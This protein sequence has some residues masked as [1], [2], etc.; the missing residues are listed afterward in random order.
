MPTTIGILNKRLLGPA[1]ISMGGVSASVGSLQTV[2]PGAAGTTFSSFNANN[3]AL[4]TYGQ[5]EVGATYQANIFGPGWGLTFGKISNGKV[6]HPTIVDCA[7]EGISTN[8]GLYTRALMC[9]FRALDDDNSVPCELQVRFQGFAGLGM[10]NPQA[11]LPGGFYDGFSVLVPQTTL[12]R[13]NVPDD[14]GTPGSS[15]QYKLRINRRGSAGFPRD[16]VTAVGRSGSNFNSNIGMNTDGTWR[17][18]Q[19]GCPQGINKIGAAPNTSWVGTPFTTTRGGLWT[20]FLYWNQTYL[21]AA[22]TYGVASNQRVWFV[23]SPGATPILIFEWFGAPGWDNNGGFDTAPPLAQ[24]TAR[25]GGGTNSTYAN[26]QGLRY[27]IAVGDNS[28]NNNPLDAK[29]YITDVKIGDTL[30]SVT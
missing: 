21:D 3:W 17:L 26:K 15:L 4:G 29:V 13:L 12:D 28:D 2:A 19:A 30:A 22:Q 1:P 27:G 11:A 23:P 5:P 7:A 24:N 9:G 10:D 8:G 18:G 25:M 20:R 14:L 16:I 6:Y